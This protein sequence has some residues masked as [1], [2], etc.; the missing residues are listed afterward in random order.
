[1][2]FENTTTVI[3]KNNIFDFFVLDSDANEVNLSI[4]KDQV[5]LIVNTAT[6]CGFAAQYFDLESLYLRYKEQGFTVLAFP[7]NQFGNQEPMDSPDIIRHCQLNYSVSFPIYHKIEV[8]GANADPLFNFLK[9]EA[10]GLLSTE[11]I[12]WNFTKFLIRR[13]GSVY[14][15]FAP[16]DSVAKVEAELLNVL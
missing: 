1:M 12:K 2:F 14:K 10:K 4:F 15:R 11:F 16:K 3:M 6:A 9:Q 13:D 7:C 8:N 5:L